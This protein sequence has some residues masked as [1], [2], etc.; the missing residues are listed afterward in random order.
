MQNEDAASFEEAVSFLF[1]TKGLSPLEGLS[2][3]I[4]C[5][6]IPHS[7]NLLFRKLKPAV[8]G[9][10]VDGQGFLVP[11]WDMLLRGLF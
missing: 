6:F 4:L 5:E 3:E 10:K 1:N 2:P 8:H 9:F 7:L 11:L